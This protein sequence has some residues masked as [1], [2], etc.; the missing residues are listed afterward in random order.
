MIL[1]ALNITVMAIGTVTLILAYYAP[2]F[3]HL[4]RT[5]IYIGDR[6]QTPNIKN[7]T[8]TAYIHV[9]SMPHLF[10][11]YFKL[12]VVSQQLAPK[13]GTAILHQ[14]FLLMNPP[15][16]TPVNTPFSQ[17]NSFS[18]IDTTTGAIAPTNP[19]IKGENCAKP[20]KNIKIFNFTHQNV[21]KPI[22]NHSN[23]A[24]LPKIRN[25]CVGTNDLLAQ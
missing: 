25:F 14:C 8:R 13:T 10:K 11:T 24:F 7:A 12:L 21:G 16:P 18:E 17:G 6:N 22:K 2:V 19:K 4:A 9:T 23:M 20:R 5:A 3:D 15:F 1:F